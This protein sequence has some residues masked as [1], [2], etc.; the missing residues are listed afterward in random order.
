MGRLMLFSICKWYLIY[1]IQ[2]AYKYVSSSL[3]LRLTFFELKI[4]IILKSSGSEDWKRV[5]CHGN[6]TF[7]SH[8]CVSCRTISLPSFNS[9]RFKLAKIAPFICLILGWVNDVISH[10]ICIFCTFFKLKVYMTD[11]FIC[12]IK[13]PQC[14]DIIAKKN[15]R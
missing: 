7:Y 11:F 1:M 3:W 13:S 6:R 14:T 8:R 9:L 2:Q 10:L 4:S 15:S 12:S 5:S